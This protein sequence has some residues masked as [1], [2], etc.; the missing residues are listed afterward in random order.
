[1]QPVIEAIEGRLLHLQEICSKN[2][3]V[4]RR[5]I[6]PKLPSSSELIDFHRQIRMVD[7]A[8]TGRV[9]FGIEQEQRGIRC[10]CG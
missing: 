3:R 1:M 5:G 10:I 9:R 8:V 4:G 6:P 7:D 2:S